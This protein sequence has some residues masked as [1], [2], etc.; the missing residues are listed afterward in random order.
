MCCE[1]MR[2][3][4]DMK[5]RHAIIILDSGPFNIND[6]VNVHIQGEETMD[7]I[8]MRYCTGTEKRYTDAL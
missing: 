5:V 1:L 2:T 8:G 3:S 6:S 7:D 4:I